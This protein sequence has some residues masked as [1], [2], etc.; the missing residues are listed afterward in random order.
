L[1][2]RENCFDVSVIRMVSNSLISRT[3]ALVAQNDT[4]FSGTVLGRDFDAQ[5]YPALQLFIALELRRIPDPSCAP[6]SRHRGSSDSECFSRASC[7]GFD[8]I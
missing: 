8:T 2:Y 6:W 4:N 1:A 5:P 3:F 7:V